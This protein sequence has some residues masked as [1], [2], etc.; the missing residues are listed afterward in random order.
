VGHTEH[1]NTHCDKA[2]QLLN[3]K[4]G[5]CAVTTGLSGINFFIIRGSMTYTKNSNPYDKTAVLY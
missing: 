1:T 2:A 5:T 3:I 4:L